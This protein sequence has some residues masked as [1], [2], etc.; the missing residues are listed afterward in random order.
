MKLY[1][2]GSEAHI[3]M[4]VTTFRGEKAILT[5]WQEPKHYGSTGRVCIKEEGADWTSRCYPSVIGAEFREED[6]R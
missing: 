1:I 3:G 4:E 6:E 5:G 2:R